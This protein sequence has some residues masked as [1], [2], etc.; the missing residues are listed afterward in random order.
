V[1]LSLLAHEHARVL[2]SL[3]AQAERPPSAQDGRF[4]LRQRP[5]DTTL[6]ALPRA[7]QL[8]WAA[9]ANGPCAQADLPGGYVHARALER[10]VSR[11]SVAIGGF[12]PS[13]ACHVLGLRTVWS[14]EAAR[15]G[16]RL[17]CRMRSGID[18]DNDG[19]V[20]LCEDVVEQVIVQAGHALVATALHRTG[21]DPSD[22]ADSLG[23]RLID[24]ALRR[25]K[26]P[27]LLG[28]A[29][30]LRRPI[31][32]IGA[33]AATYFPEIA[34]RVRAKLVV[35][36]HAAVANAVGAVAGGVV[37][38][39]RAVITSPSS[40]LFRAH[41]GTGI[42]D[43][44]DLEAA[45]CH[46]VKEVER[47]ARGQAAASGARDIQLTTRRRDNIVGDAGGAEVFIESTVE[48][49]ASGRP[50]LAGESEEEGSSS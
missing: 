26:A 1:P 29:V 14:S 24:R 3:R 30:E 20:R 11:G 21:D 15:L 48:A 5:L 50:R 49:V 10:L 16:A 44:G 38:T 19:I 32:A 27:S 13:D 34:R 28:V 47:L 18:P 8:L 22:A 41:L 31:V 9:L 2:E 33:P 39:V 12:T 37:Q 35:P 17:T 6:E 23:Q 36:E 46:A 45:A 40:G 25:E 7:Q 42:R 43:F 4:V